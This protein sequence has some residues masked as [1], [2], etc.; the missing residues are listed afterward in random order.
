MGFVRGAA[1]RVAAVS[2]VYA[3]NMGSAQVARLLALA[4]A[5]EPVFIETTSLVICSARRIS[6]VARD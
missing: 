5:N 4:L 6:V 1:L 3:R 2:V